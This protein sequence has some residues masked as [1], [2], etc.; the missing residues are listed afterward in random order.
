MLKGQGNEISQEKNY[1]KRKQ[2]PGLQMPPEANMLNPMVNKY[3][4]SIINN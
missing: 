2:Q 3:K 4:I 1:L